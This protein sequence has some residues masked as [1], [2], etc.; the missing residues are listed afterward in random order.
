MPLF[1]RTLRSSPVSI[2]RTKDMRPS[3]AHVP[4]GRMS[5][6]A[7]ILSCAYPTAI[8]ST[9]R[10][11]HLDICSSLAHICQS[12]IEKWAENDTWKR[13]LAVFT[14]LK[15]VRSGERDNAFAQTLRRSLCLHRVFVLRQFRLV[16]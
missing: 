2:K 13:T 4:S 9:A 8:C 15:E 16:L 14:R 6:T 1:G 7:C 10:S 3:S 11:L 5:S 12:R